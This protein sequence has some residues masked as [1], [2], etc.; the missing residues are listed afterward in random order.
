MQA[1]EQAKKTGNHELADRA[2]R[3]RDLSQSLPV[4]A[5]PSP[6]PGAMPA[7]AATKPKSVA[8]AER[9]KLLKAHDEAVNAL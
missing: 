6:A 2:K 7:A 5:P 4:T 3:M 1:E 8:P 9:Q